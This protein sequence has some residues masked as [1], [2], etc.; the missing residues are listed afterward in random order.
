LAGKELPAVTREETWPNDLDELA[1]EDMSRPEEPRVEPNPPRDRREYYKML[2]IRR[3]RNQ[4]E[5]IQ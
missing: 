2:R 5:A 3:K 1:A 4:K